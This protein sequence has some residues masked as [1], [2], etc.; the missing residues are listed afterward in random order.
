MHYGLPRN[1]RGLEA[2]IRLSTTVELCCLWCSALDTYL[3]VE[4]VFYKL[5]Q[6]MSWTYEMLHF[7][8]TPFMKRCVLWNLNYEMLH[9]IE[10]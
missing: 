5:L 7:M 8:G 6:N 10:S 1:I 3:H 2:G 9:V 4:L